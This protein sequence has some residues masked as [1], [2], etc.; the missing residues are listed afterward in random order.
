MSKCKKLDVQVALTYHK[1]PV[2]NN[3][4]E[5]NDVQRTLE[6]LYCNGLIPSK[7]DTIV[8]DNGDEYYITLASYSY[9]L[10]EGNSYISV[11]IDLDH[12]D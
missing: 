7:G 11:T 9:I 5:W 6:Q 10:N 4:G 3:D 2:L 1:L 12:S 8:D